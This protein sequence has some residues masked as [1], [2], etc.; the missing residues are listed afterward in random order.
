MQVF[1]K[2]LL[3]IALATDAENC[4]PLVNIWCAAGDTLMAYI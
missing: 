1:T 4:L 3:S 2:Q